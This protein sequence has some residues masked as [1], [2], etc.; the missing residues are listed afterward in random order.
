MRRVTALC[1]LA[2]ASAAPA[3][4]QS[5]FDLR[6]LAAHNAVRAQAKV[7][8]LAWDPVLA[9]GAVQHA[10]YLA[11]TGQFVHSDRR[12]RRGVG[13]NLWMGPRTS[14]EQMIGLWAAE[15]SDFLPGIFP[16][17]SRTRNWFDV[18]HYTQVVWPTTTRVGCAIRQGRLDVLVC[19]YAPAGNIDGRRVP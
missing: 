1:F 2:A 13:E 19:R 10:S 7:P 8:P 9:A 15:R 5:A 6:I 11:A 4:A 17:V 14:P 12:A 18:S 3:A 16:D